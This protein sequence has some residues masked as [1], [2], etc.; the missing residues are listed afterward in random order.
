MHV[1]SSHRNTPKAYMSLKVVLDP[2]ANTSGA[3]HARV[4]SLLPPPTEAVIDNV[5]IMCTAPPKSHS[6]SGGVNAWRRQGG[7]SGVGHL[8]AAVARAQ[9]VEALNVAV[10]D[11]DQQVVQVGEGAGR[12]A[13]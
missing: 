1:M 7:G 11:A 3:V 4:V 2:P 12:L 8:G 10:D 5:A 9:N 6:C 13:R